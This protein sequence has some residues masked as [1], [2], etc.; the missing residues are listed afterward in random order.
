LIDRACELGQKS[1]AITDHGV[2]YGV[3]DFYK[4]AKEKGIRVSF[5]QSNCEGDLVTSIQKAYKKLR[6]VRFSSRMGL[7]F[8]VEFFAGDQIIDGDYP[9]LSTPLARAVNTTPS[10]KKAVM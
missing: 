7:I 4:Y 2:M 1:I 5:Y 6:P 9:S 8:F 3:I 10:R